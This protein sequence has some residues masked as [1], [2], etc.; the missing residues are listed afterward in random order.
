MTEFNNKEEFDG[1]VNGI[2]VSKKHQ[3]NIKIALW[4]K[5]NNFRELKN[6]FYKLKRYV[7]LSKK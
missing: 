2:E 4:T 5:N 1:L 7:P 6:F 3:E